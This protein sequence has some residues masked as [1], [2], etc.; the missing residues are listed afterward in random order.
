MTGKLKFYRPDLLAHP[1]IPKPLH[2]LA[3][4][5]VKGRQ[6]WDEVRQVA[7]AENN[8]R[9]WAC[10][11]PKQEAAYRS[12]LEAHESYDIDYAT[13]RVELKEIV[14]LCHA[15]HNFIHSGRLYS[16][17]LKNEYNWQRACKI[18]ERG[19]GILGRYG[20]EPYFQAVLAQLVL[21]E[22]KT[23]EEA[24][25]IVASMG[26]FPPHD[27]PV[28]PWQDWHLVIDGETYPTRF[29][30]IHEWAEEYGTEIS[31]RIEAFV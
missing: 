4:R 29:E 31:R 13:G 22:R 5:V 19:L 2:G 27:G 11:I 17:C 1:N 8:Y 6:W 20:I 16:M 18:L 10:G 25:E 14:A 15:C 23:E 12:W 21:C 3:P 28:A 7:Y 30:D 26:L 24:L 9:C